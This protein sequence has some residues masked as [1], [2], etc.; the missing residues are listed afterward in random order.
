MKKLG[1]I[2]IGLVLAVNTFQL[3]RFGEIVERVDHYNQGIVDEVGVV[4]QDINLFAQDLNEVRKFLLL[5]GKDYSFLDKSLESSQ[6]EE[7]KAD[8]TT[9]SAV[10]GFITR[11]TDEQ[12]TQKNAIAAEQRFNAIIKDQ[13]L[14]DGLKAGQFK[15]SPPENNQEAFSVKILDAS[16]TPL[17]AL[18]VNKNN[19]VKIQS[20]IGTYN[21]NSA[22]TADL[23]KE[24]LNYFSTHQQEVKNLKELIG[25]RKNEISELFKNQEIITALAAKK[26]SVSA[27]EETEKDLN[28]NII[29]KEQEKLLTLA[30]TRADGTLKFDNQT[31]KDIAGLQPVLLDKL[32]N[33][34][35]ASGQERFIHDRQRELETIFKEQ[36]FQDMLKNNGLTLAAQPRQ[37]YNK[38]LYDVKNSEGKVMFSF[39]VELSSGMFKVLKDN[40]EIDLFST[41]TDEGSKKKI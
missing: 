7:D 29:N 10:Y 25:K 18:I 33:L 16:D 15:M 20:A 38:I 22:A 28:Y 13:T 4:R 6:L 17:Y 39:V 2:L 32:K 19:T 12:N 9:A 26:V 21:V 5:P 41:L 40:T 23:I 37:D 31:F 36:A 24:I 11:L 3:S 30:I 14:L 8:S 35:S 27:P 1:L 34:D